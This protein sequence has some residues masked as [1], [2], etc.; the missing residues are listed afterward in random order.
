VTTRYVSVE[1]EVDMSDFT[2]LDI[3]NEAKERGLGGI[4]PDHLNEMFYAFKLGRTDRA[5]EIA[6]Q[7][8]QDHK[9]MIL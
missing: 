9:G 8:A 1:V 3:E 5:L 4:D 7:I 6:R 2:D